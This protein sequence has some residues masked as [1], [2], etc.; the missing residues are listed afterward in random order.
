MRFRLKTKLVMAISGMVLA[1][2]SVLS[3]AY[4]SQLVRQRINET[5]ENGDFI[6]HQIYQV[7]RDALETDLSNTNVDE[8]NPTRFVISSK[9]IS[10]KTP[11]STR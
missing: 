5:Y 10:P 1:L 9:P 8:N 3:Y 11:V 4:L 7:S 6:A 2:V